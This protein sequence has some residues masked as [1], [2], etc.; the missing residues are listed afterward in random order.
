VHLFT[1][2]YLYD[3]DN[4]V[5]F[6]N[7]AP[8]NQNKKVEIKERRAGWSD[9][10]DSTMLSVSDKYDS[11]NEHTQEISKLMKL[12]IQGVWHKF[13]GQLAHCLPSWIWPACIFTILWPLT[14][15]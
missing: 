1:E 11:V 10:S 13:T 12:H 2:S 4:I 15:N 5:L 7:I 9:Y 3:T 14:A 8:I 6:E